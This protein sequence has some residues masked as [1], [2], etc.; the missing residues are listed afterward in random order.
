MAAEAT[1][2]QQMEVFNSAPE[3]SRGC[4]MM[5]ECINTNAT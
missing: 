3:S 1:P 2:T 4:M 5:P